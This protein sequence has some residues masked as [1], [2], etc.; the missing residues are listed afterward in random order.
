MDIAEK[1]RA[2][3]LRNYEATGRRYIC[4]SPPHYRNPWLWDSCFHAE[5][6]SELSRV[7]KDPFFID[8]AKNEILYFLEFQRE[9][10]FI[11][12]TVYYG[13]FRFLQRAVFGHY[14]QPPVIAQAIESIGDTEW[15]SGI[16]PKVLSY[17]LYFHKYRDADEDG[18][19]SIRSCYESGRDTS[20]E[21]DFFR[22]GA[23]RPLGFMN[24]ALRFRSLDIEDLVFNCL[25]IRGLRILLKLCRDTE[26]Q[27]LLNK[28][29]D[30]AESAVYELCWDKNSRFFYPLDS[31]NRQIKI[32]TIA[33][34]YPLLLENMPE[35]MTHAL[36]EHLTDPQEFWTRYPIPSLPS[37]SPYFNLNSQY[38]RSCN[39]RGPVWINTNRHIIEGLLMH[40]YQD[41]ALKIAGVN[42]EMVEREGFWEFY[43]P[44]SGEGLRIPDFAW[45]TQVLLYSRILTDYGGNSIQY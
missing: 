9:D 41:I 7:F 33:G 45:S 36:L 5:I 17:Y 4:P 3:I 8:L 32:A 28:I 37:N 26:T 44:S 23:S 30:K 21:F 18:L 31:G 40:G 6:C 38:Y 29:A 39:W 34:M 13:R 24:L 2:L 43:H 19:V 20:P 22:R 12:H 11:P 35:E 14:T 1:V 16:F 27:S 25:W 42:S 15:I 10:G